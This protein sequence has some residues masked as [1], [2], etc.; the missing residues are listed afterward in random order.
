M[1]DYNDEDVEFVK[2]M[3]AHHNKAIEMAVDAYSEGKNRDVKKWAK[4]IY[5]AQRS[6]VKKMSKWLNDR[7]E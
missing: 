1:E 2:E 3:I 5:V 4:S 6:E 7:D